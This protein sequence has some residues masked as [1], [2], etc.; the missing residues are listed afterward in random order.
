MTDSPPPRPGPTVSYYEGDGTAW[1]EY[2]RVSDAYWNAVNEALG[3][4]V[5]VLPEG[6]EYIGGGEVI[7]VM[8]EDTSYAWLG[9]NGEEPF[10][11]PYAFGPPIHVGGYRYPGGPDAD[12][13][14]FTPLVQVRVPDPDDFDCVVETLAQVAR[15]LAKLDFTEGC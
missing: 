10:D 8:Y 14:I 2:L 3:R 5:P 4:H 12:G 15:D 11:G 1:R 13:S 9:G 7:H 6:L